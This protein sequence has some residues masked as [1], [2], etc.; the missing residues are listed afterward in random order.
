MTKKYV[1]PE[2]EVRHVKARCGVC[3]QIIQTKMTFGENKTYPD[4][5][6]MECTNPKCSNWEEGALPTQSFDII[7]QRDESGNL[8][9]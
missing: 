2:I 3:H 9:E 4:D 5:F 8:I 7:E 1:S 6:Y